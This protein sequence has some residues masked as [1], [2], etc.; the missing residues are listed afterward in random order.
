[1]LKAV[2]VQSLIRNGGVVYEENA[3]KVMH[4]RYRLYG[5]NKDNE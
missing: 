4:G 5:R 1:M 3:R 2:N